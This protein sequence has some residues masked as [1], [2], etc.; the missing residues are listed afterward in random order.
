MIRIDMWDLD[1]DSRTPGWKLDPQRASCFFGALAHHRQPP[2][3][4][5]HG[6]RPGRLREPGTVVLDR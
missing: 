5:M 2:A 4:A 3:A 6:A 1:N